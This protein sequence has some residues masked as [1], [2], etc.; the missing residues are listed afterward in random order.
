ML[1]NKVA[2]ILDASGSMSG[3][4]RQTLQVVNSLIESI[5]KESGENNQRTELTFVQFDSIVRTIFSDMNINNVSSVTERD[6]RI[7]G[8]TALFDAVGQTIE[9]FKKSA[10]YSDPETSF[11]LMVV[12]DGQEN[13]SNKY[14]AES[15]TKL[16]FEVHRK[17]NWTVTFQVP[18]GDKGYL[19]NFGIPTDNIREWD[20]TVEGMKLVGQ[21]TSEG[22]QNYYHARSA[23]V[24]SVQNFYVTTDLSDVKA[25]DLKALEDKSNEFRMYEVPKESV[26]KEFVESKTKKEYQLGTTFYQLMKKEKVQSNKEVLIMDK[27]KKT[28]YGGSDAR[29]LIGLP[30]GGDAKV[31]PGNHSNYEIFVQSGSVNRKLPRGT[32]VLV[33]K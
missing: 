11:L 19:I 9:N 12:T 7:G 4:H 33:K 30:D 24:K 32:K 16:L 3:L 26:I 2:I 13:M 20:A 28:I 14:S 31:D 6:Y 15:L 21:T 1:K 18:R 10:D 27:S 5:K 8:M 25:K 29:N 17:G 23:G 22:L